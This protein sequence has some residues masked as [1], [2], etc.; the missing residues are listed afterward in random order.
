MSIVNRFDVEMYRIIEDH[1]GGRLEAGPHRLTVADGMISYVAHGDVLSTDAGAHVDRAIE[2]LAAGDIRPPRTPTGPLTGPEALLGPGAGTGSFGDV[3]VT[4]TLPGGWT[5]IGWAVV[6]GDP[7]FGLVFMEVG[8]TFTG[9]CPS[10]E[11]DPPVGPTVDDLASAWEN[12]PAFAA[13]VP[14]ATTVDGFAGKLVEFTVPDYDEADCAYGQFMLLRSKNSADG[15]WAQAP[16]Q[17]HQVRIL[18][19]DGT[20]VVIAASWYPDT[21]AQDRADIDKILGSIQI[22]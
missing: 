4:F 7:S 15:Y 2:R 12:L 6:K 22:G 19:V 21:S 3:P 1:L 20:R 9:S 10:V 14:T 11:L 16:N 5:N 13:A 18:D 8:N 17:H